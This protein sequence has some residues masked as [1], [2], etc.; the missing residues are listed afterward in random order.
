[1]NN[2]TCQIV[3]ENDL[4]P[5]ALLHCVLIH[6]TFAPDAKLTF[7]G[8]PLAAGLR[9]LDPGGVQ[10]H[11]FR[12]SGDNTHAARSVAACELG[13]LLSELAEKYPKAHFLLVG[14]SHGG[15]I[16]CAG[17]S[18]LQDMRCAGIVTMATP[19]FHITPRSLVPVAVLPSLLWGLL[20]AS[21]VGYGLTINHISHPRPRA[22]PP[23]PA[24]SRPR[25]GVRSRGFAGRGNRRTCG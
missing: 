10:F 8:S 20:A 3:S 14:H 12:W 1:M 9:K 6:G 15:N 2:G 22:G 24:R 25:A 19:F 21:W 11:R 7:P 17:A 16:A 18:A 23:S 5:D 4:S 13:C